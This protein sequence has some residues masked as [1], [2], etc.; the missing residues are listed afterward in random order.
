MVSWV[1]QTT[2]VCKSYAN[3]KLMYQL[4]TPRFT[5]L[6]TFH[7]L[8]SC[9]LYTISKGMV[10]VIFFSP[11]WQLLNN[12]SSDVDG[13]HMEKLHPWEF[14][15]PTYN[16]DVQKNVGVSCIGYTIYEGMV[17]PFLKIVLLRYSFPIVSWV[18]QMDIICKSYAPKKLRY[19]ITILGFTKHLEFHLLGSCWGYTFV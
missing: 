11:R 5:K 2:I 8:G 19:Q 1:T 14:D 4:T 7:I 3:K 17:W 13:D 18:I 16:F 6:Y 9:L 10:Q 12:L 15:V